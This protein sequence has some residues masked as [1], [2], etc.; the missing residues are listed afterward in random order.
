MKK[1]ERDLF[2]RRESLPR[3]R[4][5]HPEGWRSGSVARIH[6]SSLFLS[7]PKLRT[8]TP[9]SPHGNRRSDL[10][11][12]VSA[13]TDTTW[14]WQITGW[15]TVTLAIVPFSRLVRTRAPLRWSVDDTPVTISIREVFHTPGILLSTSANHPE[16]TTCT[17][18]AGHCSLT[19]TC[20]INHSVHT[21]I[22]N[23]SCGEGEIVRE[24]WEHKGQGKVVEYIWGKCTVFLYFP[25]IYANVPVLKSLLMN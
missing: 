23:R 11:G 10:A 19:A 1:R 12:D 22:H 5:D 4:C 6:A 14:S 2:P 8:F 3:S 24:L 18:T 20:P 9:A 25:K 15:V 13:R 7:H 21:Y 16:H 17:T